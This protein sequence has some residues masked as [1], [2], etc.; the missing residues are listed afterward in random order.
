VAGEAPLGV[1]VLELWGEGGQGSTTR[2]R[3]NVAI[4]LVAVVVVATSVAVWRYLARGDSLGE[5]VLSSVSG[6]VALI[7]PGRDGHAEVGVRIAVSDH[8]KTGKGRA[9]LSLDGGTRVRIGPSSS[10]VVRSVDEQGVGLELE[11]GALRAIVRPESGSVNVAGGGVTVQATDADFGI[12]VIDGMAVLETTR[13]EVALMGVDQPRLS[14]GSRAVIRNRAASIGPIPDDLLL[15]VSWPDPE[16][17]RLEKTRIRG[18]SAPGAKVTLVGAFGTRTVVAGED[19]RFEATVPL[20]EGKNNLV[21]SATD[22]LGNK[23]DIK[24]VLQTRDTRGPTFRGGVEYG[25]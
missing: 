25:N 4:L 5:V 11:G 14:A 15:E 20:A 7:G 22:L 21:V 6:D 9:V 10:V 23:A 8:L 16:R 2:V 19:G 1:S 3:R 24:G 18:Q 12:G 17:T 13:G